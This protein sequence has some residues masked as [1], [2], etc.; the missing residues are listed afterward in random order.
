[1]NVIQRIFFQ[2]TGQEYA[3][4]LKGMKSNGAASPEEW[5]RRKARSFLDIMRYLKQ[6][7]EAEGVLYN[8]G[9]PPEEGRYRF[10]L[11]S[12]L[13]RNDSTGMGLSLRVPDDLLAELTDC[14]QWSCEDLLRSA[15]LFAWRTERM[16][17]DHFAIIADE[18]CLYPSSIA[19]ERSL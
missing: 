16:A 3:L 18:Q 5:V 12:L 14:E 10:P 19:R 11:H 7:P 6:F 4:I 8:Q 15:C 9:I 13:Q 2:I 17:F 1:M